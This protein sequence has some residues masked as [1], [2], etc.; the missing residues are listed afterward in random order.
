MSNSAATAATHAP[1]TARGGIAAAD[2]AHIHT[3][4]H[5]RAEPRPQAAVCANPKRRV[6]R[7]GELAPHRTLRR[8]A[9]LRTTR[10]HQALGLRAWAGASAQRPVW[11]RRRQLFV[12]VDKE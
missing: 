9:R 3:H 7:H 10:R 2:H 8:R 6:L 4:M 5:L 1:S 11:P 12:G